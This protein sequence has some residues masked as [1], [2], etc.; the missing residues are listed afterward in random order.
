MPVNRPIKA[1]CGEDRDGLS[2]HDFRGDQSGCLP[3]DD[4]SFA[5]FRY[6][7]AALDI[8]GGRCLAFAERC[9]Y[10]VFPVGAGGVHVM[11]ALP[12]AG[13]QDAQQYMARGQE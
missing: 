6:A 2:A 7:F 1:T 12:L 13:G 10:H 3:F 5:Q 8:A 9:G 4:G 11:R